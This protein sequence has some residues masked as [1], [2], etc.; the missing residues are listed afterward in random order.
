MNYSKRANSIQSPGREH[1]HR[2]ALGI[3]SCASLICGRQ[4][5]FTVMCWDSML[6]CVYL[7]Q[8]SS[9]RVGTITILVWQSG[10]ARMDPRLPWMHLDCASLP[11]SCLTNG[12]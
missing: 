12:L 7:E 8:H 9:Q 2:P 10:K 4:N 3:C 1:I 5:T 6:P 11:F